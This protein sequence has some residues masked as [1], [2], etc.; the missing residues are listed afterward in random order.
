MTS[1]HAG[2]ASSLPSPPS[3]PYSIWKLI[4]KTRSYQRTLASMSVT[5]R[6]MWCGRGRAISDTL[7]LLRGRRA[8]AAIER[9]PCAG[10]ASDRDGAAVRGRRCSGRFSPPLVVGSRPG[11]LL[12]RRGRRASGSGWRPCGPEHG[13][14][15]SDQ[16]AVPARAG[17][18]IVVVRQV[19]GRD[20]VHHGDGEV[21]G[22]AGGEARGDLAAA[23]GVGD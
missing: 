11:R 2:S 10:L 6:A 1:F 12:G 8:M 22:L 5:V 15:G 16:V 7:V 9:R 20:P 23:D 21:T 13:D 17:R 4:P 18:D 3:W 14:G 19:L